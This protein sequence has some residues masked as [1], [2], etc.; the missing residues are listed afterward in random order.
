MKTTTWGRMVVVCKAHGIDIE[1]HGSEKKLIRRLPG[2]TEM[3]I[4][5]HECCRSPSSVVW[6][7]YFR[8]IKHKFGLTNKDFGR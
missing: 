6:A 8:A 4:V 7:D 3:C 2:K 1:K 5:Q